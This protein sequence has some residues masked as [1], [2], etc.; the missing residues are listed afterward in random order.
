M[1]ASEGLA[2]YQF[3]GCPFC[4]RVR[5]AAERLGLDLEL[6]DTLASALYAR[7]IEEATGRQTV[8]VL[9]IEEPDG[10]V[11]WLPESADIVAYLQ[12]RFG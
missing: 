8:P 9:R 5:D 12:E 3:H 2:L 7:E 1:A 10:R 4:R 6:R 11:R